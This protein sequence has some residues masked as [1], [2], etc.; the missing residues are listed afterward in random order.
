METLTPVERA[1]FLLRQ[2]FEYE[3]GDIAEIVGKDEVAC[4]QLF[5]RARKHI[6]DHR[7][8]FN[9][10]P[11]QHR[12]ALEQFHRAAT[13]G[14]LEGLQK[15]LA[16][17]VTLWADGGGKAKGA[18]T[19][20]LHGRE[21]VARFLLASRRLAA[22]GTHAEITRLNG[23]WSVT[24]RAGEKAFLVSFITLEQEQIRE[25]R[26]IGNPDKLQRL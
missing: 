16:E 13:A 9:P 24:L 23:E 7:P 19:Q 12:Q 15:M 4:R 22:E 2:V 25:I 14:D 5:S 11:E 17:D 10:T 21:A 18:A 8:R 1:V 26:I 3:Y 20:P 6:A